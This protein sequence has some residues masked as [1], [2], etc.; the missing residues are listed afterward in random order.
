MFVVVASVAGKPSIGAVAVPVGVRAR[1][2]FSQ[3][4]DALRVRAMAWMAS[5][6]TR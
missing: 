4:H 1:G 6:T 3:Q 5:G 2:T